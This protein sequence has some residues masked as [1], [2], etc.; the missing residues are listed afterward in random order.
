MISDRERQLW[1]DYGIEWVK[2]MTVKGMGELPRHLDYK[3]NKFA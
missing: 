1:W 2:E 3:V